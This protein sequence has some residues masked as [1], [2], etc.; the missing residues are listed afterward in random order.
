MTN[1]TKFVLFDA[2]GTL[3]ELDDFYGRLHSGFAKHGVALPLEVVTN[4]AHREM[5]HYIAH[6]I[7]ARDYNSWL[8][9]RRDC[10]YIL[11]EAI[12]EQG[13]QV[14]LSPAAA[15]KIL[16]D[17]IVFRPFPETAEVLEALQARGVWMGVISNWDYHLGQIL[18]DM[19]LAR[20]FHFILASA[21]V[22]REKPSPELFQAGI[23]QA[24]RALPGLTAQGCYYIG[25]HYEKDVIPSRAV[26]M[27]PIWLV[28]DQ[29]D[30]TSGDTQDS[31]DAGVL[32]IMTLRDLPDLFL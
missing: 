2:Y 30:L 32:R 19:K 31:D 23:E 24:H 8:A 20:F 14:P 21:Q 28:R 26:G 13:Y 25:D 4:A 27:T 11:A 9:I 10:A 15:L 12:R 18:T 1:A 16:G 29:R 22:G 7:Q 3:V 5:K 6:S 17:A